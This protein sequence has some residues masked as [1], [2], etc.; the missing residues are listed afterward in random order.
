[1]AY[2]AEGLGDIIQDWDEILRYQSKN[3][4]LFNSPS[5]TSA[6]AIHS[7]DTNALKYLDLLGN[8]FVSSGVLVVHGHVSRTHQEPMQF[9]AFI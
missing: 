5:A 9:D 6:F 4:S 8:K 1:M 7:H 3:G 2:V